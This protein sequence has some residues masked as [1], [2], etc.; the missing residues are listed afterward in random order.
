MFLSTHDCISWFKRSQ[1]VPRW[2][3]P[4]PKQSNG[5]WRGRTLPS[6]TNRAV[7]WTRT[8]MQSKRATKW[9]REATKIATAWVGR[10]NQCKLCYKDIE[11]KFWN[12]RCM[13]WWYWR[14]C[15]SEAEKTR[16]A[17]CSC[18]CPYLCL[19]ATPFVSAFS[20]FNKGKL[21]GST[22]G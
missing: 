8:T 13:V 1:V 18:Q 19:S 3:A 7:L 21:P 4:P 11:S 12:Q 16:K 17:R 22:N 15:T 14:E 6:K 9:S 2:H 20:C 10:R 5:T